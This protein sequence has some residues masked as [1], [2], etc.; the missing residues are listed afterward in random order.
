M[1]VQIYETQNVE[2]ARQLEALGVDHVGVKVGKGAFPREMSYGAT[3]EIFS[4]LVQARKVAL[5]LSRDLREVYEVVAETRPDI[6]HLGTAPEGLSPGDLRSIKQR[7]PAVA[8]M[9]TIAVVDEK[10]IEW[11]KDLADTVDYL[12]L[13][14]YKAGDNQV[15]ATGKTHDWGLS[16]AIVAAVP[17]PVILAGGLG[18]ENVAEAICQVLPAGVDSKTR[19]D[20]GHGPQKDLEKVREFVRAAKGEWKP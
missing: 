14:T 12:L 4:A 9:R 11:A 3:R 8:L 2:E 16:R 15:G 10:S 5:S 17:T 6:L 19:T 20:L 7:F 18:P 1:I 13:D